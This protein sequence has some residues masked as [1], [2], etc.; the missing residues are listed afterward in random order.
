MAAKK[1]RYSF[2]GSD[3]RVFAFYP[4]YEHKILELE[5]F[6]TLSVS[7]HD[8]KSQARALGRKNAKGVAGSVR[9][10]AGSFILTVIED[11]PLRVLTDFD[12]STTTRYEPRR[13]DQWS[14][15]RYQNGTGSVFSRLQHTNRLA[16]TLPKFN[17]LVIYM[18]EGAAFDRQYEPVYE[19]N[20]PTE[21]VR[22]IDRLT[23]A[24]LLIENI[25]II[26][27]SIVTSVNDVVSEMV[28]SY[29]ADNVL[30]LSQNKLI[31]EQIKDILDVDYASYNREVQ[32]LL[33]D[34]P[35]V[36]FTSMIPGDDEVDTVFL[37]SND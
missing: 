18:S 35:P 15:D 22:Q 10:V 13:W 21:S 20:E 29:V 4:G 19:N 36:S 31:S 34:S 8:G 23:G 2:S 16:A 24:A 12:I 9:T 3:A 14:L 33:Y 30:P 28:F 1:Y 17:L 26:D 27:E 5:S 25:S 32:E 7:C 37:S 11:H 6:N